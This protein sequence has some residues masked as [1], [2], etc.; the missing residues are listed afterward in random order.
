M[1]IEFIGIAATQESSESGAATPVNGSTARDG[2]SARTEAAAA[3]GPVVQ[4]GY[5][6]DLARTHEAAG[7]DRILVAHSSASPD[8]FTVADQIPP[9][10]KSGVQGAAPGFGKGRVRREGPPQAPHRETA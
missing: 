3:R 1:T 4:P 9:A 8:G 7:F 6:R 10:G 2:V 5:L